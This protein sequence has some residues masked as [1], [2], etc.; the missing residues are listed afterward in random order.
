[1]NWEQAKKK[2]KEGKKV[3]R[4]SWKPTF[5]GPFVYKIGALYGEDYGFCPRNTR[6]ITFTQI[7]LYKSSN[8]NEKALD[9]FVI[10]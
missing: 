3:A 2:L 6:G 1:M 8:A 10:E 9:W 4:G 5:F 7:E